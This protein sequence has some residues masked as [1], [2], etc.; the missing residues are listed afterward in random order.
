MHSLTERRLAL[1]A[2][3]LA[4][5]GHRERGMCV[6]ACN[7]ERV[8][9]HS[10]IHPHRIAIGT[11]KMHGKIS[12][13]DTIEQLLMK[14]LGYSANKVTYLSSQRYRHVGHCFLVP[15]LFFLLRHALM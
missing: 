2:N 13:N 3:G 6:C 9:Q 5:S 7:V 10:C 15:V 4:I 11:K 8:S 1:G 14:A 12:L